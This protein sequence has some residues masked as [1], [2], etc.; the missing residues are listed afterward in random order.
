M[1]EANWGSL[2]EVSN[3]HK[4]TRLY[5]VEFQN[6]NYTGKENLIIGIQQCQCIHAPMPVARPASTFK[7]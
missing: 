2:F 5:S 1:I 7:D 3:M 4:A 6:K